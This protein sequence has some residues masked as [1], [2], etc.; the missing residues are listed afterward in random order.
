MDSLTREERQEL[1]LALQA[2]ANGLRTLNPS[3]SNQGTSSIEVNAGGASVWVAAWIA[4]IACA[5]MLGMAFVGGFWML[6][7][8]NQS[9]QE[10]AELRRRDADFQDYIS[11]IYQAAPELQ[12]RIE[13]EKA[14][15]SK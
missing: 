14:E 2:V 12:K 8:T 3:Q 4:S 1:L 5:L 7:E 15:E 10:R 11:A 13:A 6:R 9:A